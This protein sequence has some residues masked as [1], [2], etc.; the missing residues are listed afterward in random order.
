MTHNQ[1]PLGLASPGR[2]WHF[3]G[4]VT[5]AEPSTHCTVT[6]KHIGMSTYADMSIH[7]C[8]HTPHIHTCTP[9]H[10][11]HTCMYTR[12]HCVHTH[13]TCIL[14]GYDQHTETHAHT[15]ELISGDWG[16]SNRKPSLAGSS[17]GL[18]KPQR[19]EVMGPLSIVTQKCHKVTQCKTYRL[20]EKTEPLSLFPVCNIQSSSSQHPEL[21]PEPA[22]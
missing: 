2:S 12:A 13:T 21:M 3:G 16:D 7:S 5:A 10:A 8:M 14:T 9:V 6:N 1:L 17:G 18:W 19:T 4:Q 15:P 11:H 20:E 22:C